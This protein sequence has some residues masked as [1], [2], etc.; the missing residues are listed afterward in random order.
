MFHPKKMGCTSL[1]I[2]GGW[3]VGG[4]CFCNAP[5]TRRW[6]QV[7]KL[8][9]EDGKKWDRPGCALLRCKELWPERGQ[10]KSQ[11]GDRQSPGAVGA[12]WDASHGDGDGLQPTTYC[13]LY[14]TA[15]QG[16]GH[17][18]PS[19]TFQFTHPR[20]L[21]VL[22]K[23]DAKSTRVPKRKKKGMMSS[24][25]RLGLHFPPSPLFS[26]TNCRHVYNEGKLRWFAEEAEEEA[27]DETPKACGRVSARSR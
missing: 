12:P 7:Q 3:Y 26:A 17:A 1:D 14:P 2:I 27:G 8:E 4:S 23:C 13:Q 24:C 10:L 25:I 9:A 18:R 20:P 6:T 16:P 21:G 19:S 5:A 15:A 22:L 11:R